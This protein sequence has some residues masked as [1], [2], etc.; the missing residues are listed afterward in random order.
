[1]KKLL[2]VALA[3]LA[4]GSL[5]FAQNYPLK[6]LLQ[7]QTINK[8]SLAKADQLGIGVNAQWLLQTSPLKDSLVTV[9]ALVTVPPHVITYTATGKTMCLVDTGANGY[10]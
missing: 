6:T 2:L 8:D 7:I 1:M 4:I 3:V 5:A 10:K 9:V